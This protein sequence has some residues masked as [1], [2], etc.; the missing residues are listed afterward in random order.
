MRSYGEDDFQFEFTLNDVTN[1]IQDK[2]LNFYTET[3]KYDNV[4]SVF[5]QNSISNSSVAYNEFSSSTTTTINI[6]DIGEGEFLIKGYFNHPLHTFVNK[7][8]DRRY[9]NIVNR[10]KGDQYGLY[11]KSTDWYFLNMY[12][13]DIPLFNIN[14]AL[15]GENNVGLEVSS[16]FTTSGVTGYTFSFVGDPI[17]NYNGSTLSPENDYTVVGTTINLDFEVLD[18]QILT[19]AYIPEGTSSGLYADSIKVA[20]INSG[21]TDGQSSSDK[22]YYN[23]TQ[24]KYE[25]YLDSE[26]NGNVVITVNGSTLISG[27]EYYIST[28]NPKRVILEVAINIGD[29]IQATY[30]PNVPFVGEVYT[31]TPGFSWSIPNKP[32]QG[33]TGTFTVEITDPSDTEFQNVLYSNTTSYIV[34]VRQYST[35]I[36]ITGGTFGDE[37]IYRIKNEK[38]YESI[39]GDIITSVAYSDVLPI[40]IATNAINSY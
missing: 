33:Q 26:P 7:Q 34:D 14:T 32:T 1:V 11:D 35:N 27:V 5:G 16:V 30:K 21:P 12:E 4:N 25:Y 29:L 40:K 36:T 8:I 15:Q 2:E 24:S 37:Y 10:K 6:N 22:V 9:D 31:L 3:Y 39:M 38:I 18:N 20:T 13:A 28:T 19:V 17:V 23:T